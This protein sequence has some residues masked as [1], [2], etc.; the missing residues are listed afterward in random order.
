MEHKHDLPPAQNPAIEPVDNQVDEAKF[1][2]R[3]RSGLLWIASGLFLMGGS[4]CV[5]YCLFHNGT[6]FSTV[7][8]LATSLGM[9]GLV[10]GMADIFGF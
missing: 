5:N 3:F 1:K 6:D 8:Y 4:F 9:V 10:K 2:R 7:M